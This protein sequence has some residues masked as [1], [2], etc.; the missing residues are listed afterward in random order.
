MCNA[1]YDE[2][3]RIQTIIMIWSLPWESMTLG[4]AN[5][6]VVISALIH[7]AVLRANRYLAALEEERYVD[8]SRMLDEEAFMNLVHAY[9]GAEKKGLTDCMVL[10]LVYDP[11]QDK[12]EISNIVVSKLRMHD[13][14]GILAGGRLGV[15]LS[16]TNRKDAE[17]VIKRIEEIG[18]GCVILEDSGE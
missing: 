8:G 10:E 18:L 7:S 17:V 9:M 3:D 12:K 15:L 1:I 11:Q 6:L 2:A 4:T 14:V 5:Q 16:N 13:Y